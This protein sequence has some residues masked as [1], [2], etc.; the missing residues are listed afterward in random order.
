[1]LIVRGGGTG[2]FRGPGGTAPPPPCPPPCRP[3]AQP[4]GRPRRLPGPGGGL[5]CLRGGAAGHRACVRR[6]RRGGWRRCGC[7]C[8]PRRARDALQALPCHRH[9]PPLPKRTPPSP[10]CPSLRAWAA[11][12]RASPLPPRITF[13]PPLLGIPMPLTPPPLRPRRCGVLRV[14]SCARVLTASR[15]WPAAAWPHPPTGEVGVVIDWWYT[16]PS[17]PPPP[18][19]HTL[20][21]PSRLPLPQPIQLSRSRSCTPSRKCPF[22]PPPPRARA[23]PG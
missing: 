20:T 1:M 4:D 10:P 19:P 8:L 12:Q 21:H 7:D 17:P 9:Q 22:T 2:C 11:R 15:S 6:R 18:S 5:L 13:A 3:R 14:M 23:C 16:V